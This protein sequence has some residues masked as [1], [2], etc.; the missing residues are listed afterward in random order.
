MEFSATTRGVPP[1]SRNFLHVVADFLGQRCALFFEEARDRVHRA[2]SNTNPGQIHS[3]HAGLRS[4]WHKLSMNAAEV[5]PA[6][7]VLFFCQHDNRTTLGGFIREGR[8]LRRIG[9]PLGAHVRCRAEFRC[10]AIAECDGAGFVEEQGVHIAGS[11]NGATA[12]GQH[13]VLNEAVHACNTDGREQSANG[14]RNQA[15]KQRHQHKHRLRCFGIHRERLQRH[16]C[17]QKDD[18]ES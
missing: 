15:D 12:H 13:V 8:K 5:A 4:E 10:L 7:V 3:A 16:Y 18:G 2:F 11:L 1:Q 9:Q 17:E 6:E 14:C